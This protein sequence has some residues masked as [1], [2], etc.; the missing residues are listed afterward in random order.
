MTTR[1]IFGTFPEGFPIL[2][3]NL[4][5]F[6]VHNMGMGIMI[7]GNILGKVEL[8]MQDVGKI[9]FIITQLRNTHNNNIVLRNTH[10]ILL[11]RRLPHTSASTKHMNI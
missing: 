4:H 8:Y 1:W 3:L 7:L 11:S 10:N 5:L 2:N 9:V 6:T